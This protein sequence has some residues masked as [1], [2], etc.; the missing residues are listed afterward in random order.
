[1]R[2]ARVVVR[3]VGGAGGLR[4][5]KLGRPMRG[6]RSP[7]REREGG[8]D[9]VGRVVVAATAT[10]TATL[11][12]TA[13]LTGTGTA[14]SSCTCQVMM[15][16]R[17]RWT[18]MATWRGDAVREVRGSVVLRVRGE[19]RGVVRVRSVGI[20]GR[21]R[22]AEREL[23]F[24]YVCKSLAYALCR[25]LTARGE[26]G[27]TCVVLAV[28][29]VRGLL[30]LAQEGV[31]LLLSC[32][33][34]PCV[35]YARPTTCTCTCTCTSCCTVTGSR[36]SPSRSRLVEVIST[37]GRVEMRVWRWTGGCGAR[38]RTE[39]VHEAR[40]SAGGEGTWS[41]LDSGSAGAKR[42]GG[43]SWAIKSPVYTLCQPDCSQLPS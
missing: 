5:R 28:V 40:S 1:M 9:R 4:E 33:T 38:T 22:T 25:Q 21:R 36:S 24:T 41:L 14:T 3:R 6:D 10:L 23:F 27:M 31:P 2:R 43:A 34:L 7:V 11:T 32:M 29:T 16:R 26:R 19:G 35:R 15:R 20:R 37:A 13:A 30:Q 17:R 42:E 12:L 39:G 18:L 8:P